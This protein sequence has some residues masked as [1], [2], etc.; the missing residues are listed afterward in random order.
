MK[1][2]LLAKPNIALL[3]RLVQDHGRS[4]APRYVLAFG[5]MAIVAAC[6]ALTAWMMSDVINKLFV[7]R[8]R[9]ALFWIPS[10]IVAIFVAKGL[11]A[12]FQEV[13]LSRAGNRIV[14]EVQRRMYDHV[15]KMDVAFFQ[16]YPSGDLI[17]R[18][19]YNAASARQMI[20]LILL[21]IGRDLLTLIGLIAVM[22]AQDPILAAIALIGGPICAMWVKRLM[23]KV[24]KAASSE[25]TSTMT[26]VGLMRETV[27][28]I[29]IAKSFQL[30]DVLRGRMFE[31]VAAVERLNNKMTRVQASVVPLVEVLGGVAVALVVMY[32]GWRNLSFGDTPGQFFSFVTALLLA[33]D[34]ARR[35]ARVPLDLATAA[36]GVR[37]MYELMDT[38]AA[39]WERSD[40]PELVVGAGNIRFADVRF[41]YEPDVPVLNGLDLDIAAGKTNALVGLS[42]SGKTTI[43][44]LVQRFWEPA[45][46]AVTIDGQS[47]A[48]VSLRS[49][50]RQISLV[51]QDLFLFEGTIRDNIE[52][53]QAVPDAMV[54]RAA[55]AAHADLFI[56]ELPK[57]YDT[58]VGELG[59]QLSGGQRQRISIA[60]AFLKD[61]PIILLDEPT[62]ALDSEAEQAIQ[63]V[64]KNLMRGRTTIV[65]AHRLATIVNAHVI[66]VVAGGRVVESGAHRELVER[67]GVYAKLHRLQF[68]GAP[69]EPQYHVVQSA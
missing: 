1:N 3:L 52:A 9:A 29:R 8:D 43:F 7:D 22:V 4:Y 11:A 58:P 41:A 61:A 26:I 39:E 10:A 31:A 19:T 48:A 55:R 34:P 45:S 15:L 53:G 16:R 12:Y 44:N 54:E 49:L 62:S 65:I 17:T 66:H 68:A 64:L 56:R 67:G 57:G 14:A 33:A 28:G 60:R 59:L 42:G 25:I 30:E 38:P 63:E 6:T 35:L 37:M 46:G 21:G 27:Q 51:S 40:K 47:I 50:R 20:N 69:A 23:V 5:C 2:R 24:R 13:T 36:I 18:I 32:A